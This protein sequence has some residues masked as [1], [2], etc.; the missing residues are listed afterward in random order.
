MRQS[1][2]SFRHESL[3][4]ANTIQD[5]LKSLSKGIAKGKLSFSDEDGEIVMEP[6]GLLNLKVTASQDE[7]RHRV[8]IRIT[9]QAEE[10]VRQTK[11]LRV[12]AGGE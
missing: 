5:I 8:N 12:D 1:K 4:D 7:G 3:Q 2:N 11:P 9:W 6:E 10:T